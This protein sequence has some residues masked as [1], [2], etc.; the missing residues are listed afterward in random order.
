MQQL[1]AE[2]E[3]EDSGGFSLCIECNAPLTP[4]DRTEVEQRVP[5]FVFRTQE[6]FYCCPRCDKLY[7]RGTHWR[8][9]RAE[10]ASFMEGA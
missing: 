5:P 6:T 2:L 1:A 3:L 7:W 8:N 4:I 9:M 10:L